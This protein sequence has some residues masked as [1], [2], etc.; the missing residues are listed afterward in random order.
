MK[1]AALTMLLGA[2]LCS[3]AHAAEQIDVTARVQKS[4]NVRPNAATAKKKPN[5]KAGKKKPLPE[6]QE[7]AQMSPSESAEQAVQLRGV[8]G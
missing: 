7:G 1:L 5:K 2:A 8:R 3:G 6:S 4:A